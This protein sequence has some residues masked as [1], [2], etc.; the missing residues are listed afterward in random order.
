MLLNLLDVLIYGFIDII[1]EQSINE[2]VIIDSEE[3]HV[4]GG[5]Y[6]IKFGKGCEPFSLIFLPFCNKFLMTEKCLHDRHYIYEC[7][8]SWTVHK[9]AC[10]LTYSMCLFSSSQHEFS[11]LDFIAP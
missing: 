10:V 1:S 9:N 5:H 8:D 2:C 4:F 7:T 11:S 6:L 3:W